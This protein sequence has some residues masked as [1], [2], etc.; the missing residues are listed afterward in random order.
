[1]G[2][3]LRH[4][5]R[6]FRGAGSGPASAHAVV[7]LSGEITSANAG[8][9]GR[10][11]QQALHSQAAVLEIDLA[12]VTYLS[13]DGAAAVFTALREAKAGGTKVIVTH[14]RRQA[15]GVLEQLGL[16]RVVDMY[17]GDGPPPGSGRGNQ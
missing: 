13:G 7:R 4:P 3:R 12:E 9:I 16:A 10:Q 11:L 1:M 5:L 6:V 15:V 17:A 8:R 2:R 14:V